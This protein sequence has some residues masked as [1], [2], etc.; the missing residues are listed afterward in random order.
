VPFP[1]IADEGDSP[2]AT[3]NI[4]RYTVRL[5]YGTSKTVQALRATERGTA[6]AF[7]GADGD[8][9]DQVPLA[10]IDELGTEETSVNE[11]DPG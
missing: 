2:T 4:K 11:P 3:N 1:R 9:V 8:V 10:D 6:L 7:L 5:R